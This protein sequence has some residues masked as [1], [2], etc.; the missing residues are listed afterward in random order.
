MKTLPGLSFTYDFDPQTEPKHVLRLLTQYRASLTPPYQSHFRVLA[1]VVYVDGKGEVGHVCGTNS[2]QCTISGSICAERAAL[3]SLRHA[4]TPDRTPL[5]LL[6]VY[7]VTDEAAPLFPG[8]LCKEYL[9]SL[10]EDEMLVIVAG[11]GVEEI[12]IMPLGKLYPFASLY[13]H[14]DR[15]DLVET[16]QAF[17]RRGMEVPSSQHVSSSSSGGALSTTPTKKKSNEKRKTL[18]APTRSDAASTTA[19]AAELYARA[20]EATAKDDKDDFHPIRYAAGV[21]FSDGSATIAW[22]KK[23]IEYGTTVDAMLQLVHVI[24]IKCADTHTHTR[25]APHGEGQRGGGGGRVRPLLLLQVD[26]FGILHAP[27]G[28]MRGFL[29]EYGYED[30][31]LLV[32]DT[33]L[34]LCVCGRR[35]VCVGV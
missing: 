4:E 28:H 3:V 2:E 10:A 18:P 19:A 24:E 15:K 11:A 12:Q 9:A 17:V 27:C 33:R 1:V 26:Q 22:Q 16:A 32:H 14:V 5:K 6:R 21:L 35:C 23:G 30:V 13:R 7:V 34:V 25:T 31:P 29:M 20:C 8:V